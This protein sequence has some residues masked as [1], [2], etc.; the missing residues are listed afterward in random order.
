VPG[1]IHTCVVGKEKEE[2]VV[3]VEEEEPGLFKAYGVREERIFICRSDCD[4]TKHVASTQMQA[5][6]PTLS[7]TSTPPRSEV[8]RTEEGTEGDDCRPPPSCGRCSLLDD[9]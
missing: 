2:E 6:E 7:Y 4:H 3:V 9:F 8:R 5:Q 1:F